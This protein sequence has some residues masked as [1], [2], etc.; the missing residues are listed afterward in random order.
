[1]EKSLLVC[2]IIMKDPKWSKKREPQQQVN[3]GDEDEGQCSLYTY[4]RM[5]HHPIIL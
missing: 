3:V 4:M 1:M 5:S 2:D